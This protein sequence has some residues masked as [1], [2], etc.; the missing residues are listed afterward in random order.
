LW[1]EREHLKG[2][3]MKTTLK[4]AGH[5]GIGDREVQVTVETSRAGITV[6]A[7]LPGPKTGEAFGDMFGAEL[8]SRLVSWDEYERDDRS[9]GTADDL[10]RRVAVELAGTVVRRALPTKAAGEVYSDGSE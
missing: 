9:R 2:T 7:Y 8:E 3:T 10:L 1:D 4:L 5:Y 6:T